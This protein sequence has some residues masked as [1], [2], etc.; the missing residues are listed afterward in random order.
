MCIRLSVSGW[1]IKIA[2]IIFKSKEA[3]Q[4]ISSFGAI[5]FFLRGIVFFDPARLCGKFPHNRAGSKNRFV[6]VEGKCLLLKEEG[7]L[8]C[9]WTAKVPTALS[10]EEVR[11]FKSLCMHAHFYKCLLC[12]VF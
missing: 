8:L 4:K 1:C 12:F 3:L 9:R 7:V 6:I 2:R 5:E 11:E 10:I